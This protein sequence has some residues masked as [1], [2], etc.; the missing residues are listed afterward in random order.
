MAGGNVCVECGQTTSLKKLY[1]KFEGGA[2]RI[3]FCESCDNIMDKYLEFDPV[4]ICLD[5][6][7]H[8]PQAYRH[9]LINRKPKIQWHLCVLYLLCDAYVK[10]S[11]VNSAGKPVSSANTKDH[12]VL[13]LEFYYILSEACFEFLMFFCGLF[14]GIKVLNIIY[15]S[16]QRNQQDFYRELCSAILLS[17]FGKLLVIPVVLWSNSYSKVCLWLV[18]LF[19]FTSNAEAIKVV[20]S[21]D[22]LQSCF[23][24]AFGLLVNAC[25]KQENFTLLSSLIYK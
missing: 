15:T 23:V 12:S 11:D 6:L 14:L 8:K 25:F 13:E 7:L 3:L 21:M 5:V 2:I 18:K 4:L 24:V 22:F 19:V 17:S 9:V 10:W 20:L 16:K 1:R